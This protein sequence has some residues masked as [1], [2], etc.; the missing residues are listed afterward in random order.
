[1]TT[2][3]VQK[4]EP[5]AATATGAVVGVAV[6][7]PLG[8]GIGAGAG[9]LVDWW[10]ERKKKAALAAAAAAA[11]TQAASSATG[12]PIQLM[13][14]KSAPTPLSS[15]AANNLAQ[16][17]ASATAKQQTAAQAAAQKAAQQQ[18]AKMNALAELTLI[19]ATLDSAAKKPSS[20]GGSA[21]LQA[22]ANFS[23]GG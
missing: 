22:S 3:V 10:R 6:G 4:V 21:S 19:R 17:V 1:M 23:L 13:T 8:L 5:F 16:I 2:K 20:G 15:T 9:A 18:V 12:V 14:L 11:N 7:G